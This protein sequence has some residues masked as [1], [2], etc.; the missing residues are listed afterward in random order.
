MGT[1]IN[2]SSFTQDE[3]IRY[4]RHFT[5][6][7]VGMAGQEKLKAARV[8]CVG[9]GGL[10]SPLLQYLAAAGIGTIGIIDND[11]VDL[12]NLQRQILY[13][14]DDLGLQKVEVAKKKLV[15][16]NPHIDIKI[17]N[18]QL[19]HSNALSIIQNY[20]IVADGTDNFAARYLVNDA[21]FHLKKPN[22]YASIFQFEGQ[23]SVFNAENGPCYR[24]LYDAPPPPGLMPNCAEGGVLGVLPGIMGTIQALEVVKLILKIGD[25]LIGR[26]LTFD[27]LAMRFQEYKVQ[28]YPDCRLC[29]HQQNFTDLPYHEAAS[30][31]VVES[32]V[33]EISVQE[34]WQLSQQQANYTLLDI[35]EPYE[36][37]ICNLGGQLIPLASLSSQLAKLDKNKSYIAYCRS[38]HRSYEAVKIMKRAG[39]ISVKNLKGGI[40]AWANSIDPKMP[41]Y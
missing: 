21:C 9:A 31:N 5:L 36:Q 11:I 17:Y 19:T 25:P 1:Q 15:S 22:V 8:L 24:C 39:F 29:I 28:Q 33:S 6:P 12:S 35:R 16:L 20:D 7:G 41:V 14:N 18:E 26:L 13:T 4:S 37:Q 3:F 40:L 32:E 38:G 27:A 10:G 2:A 30:C 34:L 23:C